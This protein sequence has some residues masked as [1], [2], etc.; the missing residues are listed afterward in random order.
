MFRIF[1][2]VICGQ[3]AVCDCL[4]GYLREQGVALVD[5]EEARE[6]GKNAITYI[7]VFFFRLPKFLSG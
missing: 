6:S 7:Q 5:E 1:Q 4:Q 3:Q 2:R